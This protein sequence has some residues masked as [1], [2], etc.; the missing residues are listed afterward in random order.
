MKDNQ[1]NVLKD[2]NGNVVFGTGVLDQLKIYVPGE[3]R[4]TITFYNMLA[5]GKKP[6][7]PILTRAQ[8]EATR[9][10]TKA[11]DWYQKAADAGNIR[12]KGALARLDS[13]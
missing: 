9:D 11:R 1:G 5:P 13:N 2:A 8:C 7:W 10:P 4:L 3:Q 12:G 6:D